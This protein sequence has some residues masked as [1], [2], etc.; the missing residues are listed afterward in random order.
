MAFVGQVKVNHRGCELGVPQ[1]VLDEL[2]IDARF[3]QMGG[4]RMSEG[5]DGDAHFGDAGPLL[6]FA[7]GALD[8]GA[9]HGRGRRRALFLIAPSGG[10]E[11]GLVPMGFPVGAQ[12]RKRIGGQRDIPVLGALAAM[13]MDLEALAV[14]IGDLQGE[15]FVEPQAQTI[16][17]GEVDL[18][19]QGG[20][21]R[22]EPP[23]L[24]HTEDGGKTVGSLRA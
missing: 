7:E 6:G 14:N 16:D 2:G 8:T 4:V 1:G 15:G 23:D 19:M 5:M 22:Q 24:L 18:V 17:R 11:P 9:P 10:K 21:G 13:D 12:Q 20:S 3:K